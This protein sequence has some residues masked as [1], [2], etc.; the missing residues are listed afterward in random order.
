M[1][2]IPHMRTKYRHLLAIRRRHFG[3]I[4]LHQWLFMPIYKRPL[5]IENLANC[6]IRYYSFLKI[7]KDVKADWQISEEYGEKW[8]NGKKMA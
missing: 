7:A 6:E 3:I 4:P 1:V 8:W 2:A 5:T